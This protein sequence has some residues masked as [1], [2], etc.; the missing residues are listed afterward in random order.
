MSQFKYFNTP[1]EIFYGSVAK[2]LIRNFGESAPLFVVHLCVE[3]V[4]LC[5]ENGLEK[6]LVF[7]LG[8]VL[9]FDQAKITQCLEFLESVGWIK[10][11]TETVSVIFADRAIT[12]HKQRCKFNK[13]IAS[14]RW[15]N[16][17][18]KTKDNDALHASRMRSVCAPIN[19]NINSNLNSNL[20]SNQ[21]STG[22]EFERG[23]EAAEK[24]LPTDDDFLGWDDPPEPAAATPPPEPPK[25][26]KTAKL[27]SS[28]LSGTAKIERKVGAIERLV[29]GTSKP[30]WFKGNEPIN[31]LR[32]FLEIC[33]AKK[34]IPKMA[35]TVEG[36]IAQYESLEEFLFSI[37][38]SIRNE[39]CT[40]LPRTDILKKMGRWKFGKE[41]V[42]QK[43]IHR[44]PPPER[45]PEPER[46]P[47]EKEQDRL[48]VIEARKKIQEICSVKDLADKLDM[49]KFLKNGRN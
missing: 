17:K 8:S 11:D 22:G 15:Q 29:T 40:L 37:R 12:A 23:G 35:T 18:K 13:E 4:N 44:P 32:R 48:K 3:Q 26:T 45:P 14:D 20:T 25:P 42:Q 5:S 28:K 6:S 30:L 39:W 2:R 7:E 36:W 41:V 43:Y 38:E 49:N 33:Q 9:G 24:L 1:L 31:E 27:G 47:E 16:E 19:L 10:E 34:K 46:T 21:E